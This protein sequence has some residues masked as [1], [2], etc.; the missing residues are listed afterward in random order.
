VL[1][2]SLSVSPMGRMVG[3]TRGVQVGSVVLAVLGV[4][5]FWI[6]NRAGLPTPFPQWVSAMPSYGYGLLAGLAL[7]YGGVI[8]PM[9]GMATLCGV[10]FLLTDEVWTVQPLLAAVLFWGA[11]QVPLRARILPHLGQVAFGI[12][13]T[14]PFFL[15]VCYKMF[16]AGVSVW[17]ALGLTFLMSWGATI[18]LRATPF[19]RRMV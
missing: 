11:W 15:L 4:G 12:Y 9:L 14:H 7:I 18:G 8:W 17:L 1:L 19:L 3:S 16:G 5:A 2:A 6:S 10:S 13:L